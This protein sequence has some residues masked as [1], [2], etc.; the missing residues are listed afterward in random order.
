MIKKILKLFVLLL[1]L[2]FIGISLFFLTFD[3]N[4]YR[5][6]IAKQISEALGRQASIGQIELK[7][8]LIPTITLKNVQLE[9]ASWSKSTEPMVKIDTMNVNFAFIPLLQ[10]EF[11]M[12]DFIIN[13]MTVRLEKQG[14]YTNWQFDKKSDVELKTTAEK[15]GAVVSTDKTLPAFTA[16]KIAVNTLSVVYQDGNDIQNIFL[17]DAVIQ[18]LKAFSAEIIYNG[19][20]FKV[21]GTVDNLLNLIV[22]SPN[23]SFEVRLDAFNALFAV[24]GTIGNVQQLKDIYTH[25]QFSGTDFNSFIQSFGKM[26][27]FPSRP[28]AGSFM[29]RGDLQRMLL[30]NVVLDIGSGN[31]LSF[32]ASGVLENLTQK[33]VASVSAEVNVKEEDFAKTL[34]I[35]PFSASFDLDL[36]SDE[37]RFNRIVFYA[38]KSDIIG[39]AVVTLSGERPYIMAVLES[40]YLSLNDFIPESDEGRVSSQKTK[41]KSADKI[42]S[43]KTIDFS[44]LNMFDGVV[45]VNFKNIDVGSELTDFVALN[46]KAQLKDGILTVAPFNLSAVGGVTSGHITVSAKKEPRMELSLFAN[47][48]KTNSLKSMQSVLRDVQMNANI[49]LNT[50]GN[51]VQKMM[52][53]LNGGV[54]LEVLSGSIVSSAFN[55]LPLPA[56]VIRNQVSSVAFSTSDQ[57]SKIICGAANIQIKDGVIQLDKNIALETSTVNFVVSGEINLGAE[58]MSVSMLPSVSATASKVT[59]RVLSLSQAVKISGP[60]KALKPS[61]DAASV[62]STVAK[63]GLDILLRDKL[64]KEEPQSYALCEKA[65][66]RPFVKEMPVPETVQP[67]Q[68]PKAVV[69]ENVAPPVSLKDQFKRDLLNSLSKAL[70]D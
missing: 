20:V 60:F 9:N 2:I 15:E 25:V 34:N 21:S 56:M 6:R 49:N 43:D 13:R 69:Q 39:R 38:E 3:I 16:D 8:S 51:S 55:S 26:P 70:S 53:H 54:S 33:P 23:Y 44:V 50:T 52:S 18:Q 12:K 32:N 7:V 66:G 37:M 29:L 36:S 68:T 30:E 45:S 62:S 48:L 46:T 4:S 24:S 5:N 65:L 67:K 59:N 1:V 35:K 58:N 61:L 19:R 41:E 28:F 22:G 57:V 27:A 40:E 47:G 63:A 42:F 11:E 17:S 64:G 31:T 10:G 14:Q